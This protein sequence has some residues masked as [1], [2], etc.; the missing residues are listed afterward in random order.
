MNNL[1]LILTCNLITQKS[2]VMCVGERYDV[3]CA[4]L[5]LDGKEILFVHSLKYLS[6]SLALNKAVSIK[7]NFTV[8]GCNQNVILTRKSIKITGNYIHFSDELNDALIC[9]DL[10]SFWKTWHSKF[11]KTKTSSDC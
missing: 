4:P 3:M 5:T 2:V 9:K 11:S 1:R 7:T 8:N 10:N 6:I